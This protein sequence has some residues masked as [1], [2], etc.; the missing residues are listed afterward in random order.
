MS[1]RCHDQGRGNRLVCRL[2]FSIELR[3]GYRVTA[4]ALVGGKLQRVK[5]V[6][7]VLLVKTLCIRYID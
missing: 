4:D 6:L 3:L 1:G 2:V 5:S 7:R